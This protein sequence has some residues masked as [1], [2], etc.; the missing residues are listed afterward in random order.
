MPAVAQHILQNR[1]LLGLRMP[2]SR[3]KREY[4]IVMMHGVTSNEWVWYTMQTW[5]KGK[6]PSRKTFPLSLYDNGESFTS[7]LAQLP[8]IAEAIRNNPELADGYDLVC[9]S[10]GGLI[11]RCLVEYMDRPPYARRLISLAGPQMGVYGNKMEWGDFA[12][13][14]VVQLDAGTIAYTNLAQMS[15][16]IANMWND[17]LRHDEFVKGNLFIALYNGLKDDAERNARRKYNFAKL[18][19]A[20]FLVGDYG[21]EQYEGGIE[22]WQSGIF[23]F[24]KEGSTTE[25]VPM[26]ESEVFKKDTFGLK[27]LNDTGRLVLHAVPGVSHDQWVLDGS[28][29]DKYIWPHL[30]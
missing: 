29:F 9:H 25:I 18:E 6:S 28:M 3:P 1:K 5:I 14:M 11:C 22:P 8:D 19:K 24:Y 2:W 27:T 21:A 16:S 20:V 13:N 17:P 23:G 7:L 26:E 12:K 30:E 15:N 10:Q 4:P